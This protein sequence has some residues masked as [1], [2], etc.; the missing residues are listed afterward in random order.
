M[1]LEISKIKK[2]KLDKSILNLLIVNL[3]ISLYRKI[4]GTNASNKYN[5]IVITKKKKIKK[6]QNH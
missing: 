2:K 5:K 3:N 1:I 4:C 6:I